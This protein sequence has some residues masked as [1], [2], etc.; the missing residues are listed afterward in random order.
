MVFQSYVPVP[1]SS[2]LAQSHVPVKNPV[3]QLETPEHMYH[4]L[5][6]IAYIAYHHFYPYVFLTVQ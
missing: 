1:H 5:T 4:T 6:F 2:Q 3:H